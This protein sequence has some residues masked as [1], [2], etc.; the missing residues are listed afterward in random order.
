M[1]EIQ[2]KKEVIMPV[3]KMVRESAAP[4]TRRP[5]TGTPKRPTSMPASSAPS[6]AAT[7]RRASTGFWGMFSPRPAPAATASASSRRPAK[8]SSLGG[9]RGMQKRDGT[10]VAI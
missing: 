4:A 1:N 3:L 10:E 7:P 6:A 9:Q 2:V 8:R 5:A